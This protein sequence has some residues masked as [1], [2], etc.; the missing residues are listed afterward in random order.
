MPDILSRP[1]TRHRIL[2]ETCTDYTK[3]VLRDP[4]KESLR[5]TAQVSGDITWE[6]WREL[7][8]QYIANHT[9]S[10]SKPE[11]RK[12]QLPSSHFFMGT[13]RRDVSLRDLV[14]E[15]GVRPGPFYTFHCRVSQLKI[16]AIYYTIVLE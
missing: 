14:R 6:R 3:S 11:H 10:A 15:M 5:K 2:F 8:G 1:G 13:V 4:C 16:H 12:P 7:R 9:A